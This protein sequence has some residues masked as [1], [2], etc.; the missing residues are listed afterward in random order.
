MLVEV[1]KDLF[2]FKNL[3]RK[4]MENNSVNI[5]TNIGSP[6][7]TGSVTGTVYSG[8]KDSFNT[9]GNQKSLAEAAFEIQQL[10]EQLEKSYPSK[11]TVEKLTFAAEAISRIDSDPKLRPKVISALKAGGMQALAQ[12]LNHPVVSFFIAALEDWQNSN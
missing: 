12:A 11:T 4:N 2:I 7:V 9:Y 5:G 10:L 8:V 3:R 1:I 6:I